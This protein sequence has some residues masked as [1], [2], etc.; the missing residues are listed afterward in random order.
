MTC[1]V[2]VRSS[3]TAC[4][5]GPPCGERRAAD[6]LGDRIGIMAQ[7]RL[8]CLGTSVHLK[9][10]FGKVIVRVA[11]GATAW[12]RCLRMHVH[13]HQ[14][15]M[16]YCMV[17]LLTNLHMA[18][19]GLHAQDYPCCQQSSREYQEHHHGSDRAGR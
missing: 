5:P 17:R 1:C 4:V 3:T 6:I 19:Q 9:S 12:Q 18:Y 15:R 14:T 7:G 13:M 11:S 2:T 16:L 10:K 8:R